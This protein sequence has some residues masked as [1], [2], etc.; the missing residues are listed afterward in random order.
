MGDNSNDVRLHR[1]F[2]V[3]CGGVLL[4]FVNDWLTGCSLDIRM[5]S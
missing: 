4:F 2:E 3:K 5:N 1:C